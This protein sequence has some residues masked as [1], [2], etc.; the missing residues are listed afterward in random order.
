M[1]DLHW[2][3][4]ILTKAIYYK[5][6]TAAAQAI[7]LSQPQISR[8]MKKIENELGITLLDKS[9]PRDTVWTGRARQLAE[10]Y[11]KSSRYL[12]TAVLKLQKDNRPRNITIGTLEGL[13]GRAIAYTSA[14]FKNIHDIQVHLDVYDQNEMESRFLMGEI[15]LIF[16]SRYPGKK[17][18][19]HNKILGYQS[20]SIIKNRDELFIYSPYEFSRNKKKLENKQIL[21]SNSLSI[22]SNYLENG[23]GTGIIPSPISKQKKES[24]LPVMVIAQDYIHHSL[25]QLI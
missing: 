21:I 5:N 23:R 18:F 25:W 24:N 12:E 9:S 3:L 15:D 13:S 7:G 2:P 6:A 1:D 8:L 19:I 17:K 16:S 22:R 11:N 4:H 20:L 14:L 10:I